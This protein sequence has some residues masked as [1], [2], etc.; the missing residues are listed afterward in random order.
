MQGKKLEQK[1]SD[2]L[3]IKKSAPSL[4]ERGKE[5]ALYLSLNI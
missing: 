5:K 4:D 1:L 2:V 3:K